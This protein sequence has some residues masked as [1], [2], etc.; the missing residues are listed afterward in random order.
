MENPAALRR[1]GDAPPR[2]RILRLRKNGLLKARQ[3]GYF[4]RSPSMRDVTILDPTGRL[5]KCIRAGA[6]P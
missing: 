3:Q 5:A 1:P 2:L 4:R 6:D